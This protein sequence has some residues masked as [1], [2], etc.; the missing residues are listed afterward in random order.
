MGEGR[1]PESPHLLKGLGRLY[2]G[3]REPPLCAAKTK[4]EGREPLLKRR[5]VHNP[6]GQ[7]SLQQGAQER[8]FMG[9]SL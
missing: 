1:S 9:P 4:T 5:L 7:V 8:V 6:L 2:L 3:G